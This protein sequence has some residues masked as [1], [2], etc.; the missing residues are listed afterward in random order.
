MAPAIPGRLQNSLRALAHP[1]Y[2]RFF[3]GH[4]TSLIGTW[5]QRIAIGW[6]VYRLTD[7]AFMLGVVGFLGPL[8]T[9][10]LAP[11]TGV[12]ADRWDRRRIL[13]VTQALAMLQALLLALLVFTGTV[14]VWHVIA[15]GVALGVVNA[16]D[17]PARQSFIIQMVGKKEDL[18]NAIA[19]NSGMVNGARLVGPSVAGITIAAAG[20]GVCFLLNA[21]SYA[22][23]LW[24][25]WGMRIAPLPAREHPSVKEGL[26][27]GWRYVSGHVPIRT[28]MLLLCL[29][30]L[31]AVPYTTL[32]PV[33]ARDILHGGPHLLG[34]LMAAVGIGALGGAIFLATRPSALGLEKMV[35]VACALFGLG[36]VLFA[37]SPVWWLSLGLVPMVGFGMMVQMASS[38][39]IIQT[40]VD[41]DKRGRVMSFYTMSFMGMSP[42]GSLLCGT[43]AERFGAPLTLTMGGVCC[44]A[45]ALVFWSR[46]RPVRSALRQTMGMTRVGCEPV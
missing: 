11:V 3:I 45:G 32:M 2:R 14:Q 35:A 25:L 40:I 13:L 20:E 26:R 34:F 5:M 31:V 4:G 8:P 30:S 33:F 44:M 10:L 41:D 37:N 17:V 6:L 19:L 16:F 38:N 21:L 28:L 46:R 39:T 22:A 29:V 27:D 23:I 15:L 24:A 7:S 36:L 9:F 43:L 42:F 18:G 1:N 12:L